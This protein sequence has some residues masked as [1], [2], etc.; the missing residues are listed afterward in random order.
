MAKVAVTI[1]T[2]II[3]MMGKTISSL[4]ARKTSA[5]AL[6]SAQL[7]EIRVNMRSPSYRLQKCAKQSS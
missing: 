3:D 5:L 1:N 2:P 7:F 6:T 4:S